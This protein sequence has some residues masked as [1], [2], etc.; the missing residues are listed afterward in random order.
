MKRII[1]DGVCVGHKLEWKDLYRFIGV[2][3]ILSLGYTMFKSDPVVIAKQEAFAV[4]CRD[5]DLSAAKRL[6]DEKVNV[7][8]VVK[9][10]GERCG[11]TPLYRACDNNHTE[12]VKVLLNNGAA[13]SL[14]IKEKHEDLVPLHRSAW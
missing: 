3:V 8:K 2:V 9:L 10:K 5:G 7:N 14:N 13:E 6:I 11:Y 1:E 4:A 12:V